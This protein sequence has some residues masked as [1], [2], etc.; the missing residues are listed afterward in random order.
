VKKP[1]DVK[2]LAAQAK[3]KGEPLTFRDDLSCGYARDVDALLAGRGRHQPRQGRQPHHDSAPADGGQH[4]GGQDG[5][6]LRGEPW[7][8]RAIE[9]GIG[10]TVVTTQQ[11]WKDHP[12][13]VCAFTEEFA[14]KNPKTVKAVL[15]A[16]HLA[17][18]DL[19]K[20]ENRP[21][22]A[23]I[24][25]RPA[26]INCPPA[27]I[28]ERL[29]GKY[30]YGD[31]RVEQDPNYMIYSSRAAIIRS[32]STAPGTSASSAGGGWSS[33]L[34]ITARRHEEGDASRP[35]SRRDEG[36]GRQGGGAGGEDRHALRQHDG[37]QGSGKVR[38]LVPR[39]QRR[40]LN[41]NHLTEPRRISE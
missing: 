35:L 7:N 5:R 14:A 6:L 19:D 16:L 11:M 13:K 41:P 23:E 28:L 21:K 30:N 26:Y 17:S 31:G 33:R 27:T 37:H 1:A 15:K 38:A 10:Y 9:D 24:I 40:E 39:Q 8:N 12:E 34:R 22:F 36:T 32:P 25:A 18:V 20:M 4:E 29:M 3:A 2:P